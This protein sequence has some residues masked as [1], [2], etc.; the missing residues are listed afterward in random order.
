MERKALFAANSM[1][2]GKK[3]NAAGRPSPSHLPR[4]GVLQ[5]FPSTAGSSLHPAVAS[6]AGRFALPLFMYIKYK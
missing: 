1:A 3:G 4:R 5:R 6:M 2:I